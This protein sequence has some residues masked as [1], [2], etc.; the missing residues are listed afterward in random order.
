MCWESEGKLFFKKKRGKW[1]EG[2]RKWFGG[3]FY[4]T[5]LYVVFPLYLGYSIGRTCFSFFFWGRAVELSSDAG[6]I[7]FF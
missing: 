6:G 7:F 3:K 1:G 5:L 4:G 2:G